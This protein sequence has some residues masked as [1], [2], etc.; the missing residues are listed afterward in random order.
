MVPRGTRLAAG[1]TKVPGQAVPLSLW[2]QT[3]TNATDGKDA[4]GAGLWISLC[5]LSFVE[6][7][8]VADRGKCMAASANSRSRAAGRRIVK[9]VEGERL[10]MCLCVHAYALNG[11]AARRF[12]CAKEAVPTSHPWTWGAHTCA[13]GCRSP[14]GDKTCS[15]KAQVLSSSGTGESKGKCFTPGPN[16]QKG[17][18]GPS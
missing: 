17:G 8:G 6:G 10:F 15:L 14:P 11:R 18:K 12:F 16:S 4:T 7:V 2:P 5:L 1:Q 3:P 9:R 13:P